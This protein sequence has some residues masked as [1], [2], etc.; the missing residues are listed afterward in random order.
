MAQTPLGDVEEL[1]QDQRYAKYPA[2][3]FDGAGRL[4]AAWTSTRMTDHGG[5]DEIM[6]RVRSRGQWSDPIRLDHGEGFE[7]GVDLKLDSRG[8]LWA[9]WHGLRDGRWGLYSRRLDAEGPQQARAPSA[10]AANPATR[11]SRPQP[12]GTS[13]VG[14]DAWAAERLLT[15]QGVDALHPVV[16]AAA[17]E[18]S[19]GLWVAYEVAVE[20]G[21]TVE[22]RRL[23]SPDISGPFHVSQPV[24][25]PDGGASRRPHLAACPSGQTYLAWDSTLSG[26]YDV[27]LARL[28]SSP[29]GGT[30]SIDDTG[31]DPPRLSDVQPVT[32][33]AFID[34]SPWLSCAPDGSL[35]VAFNSMR[36]HEDAPLRTDRHSGD[37]FIRVLRDGQWLAPPGVAPGA[38]AG[39]VSFGMTVKTPRD[40]VDPYWH[41]KQT[42]N[43]PRVFH[44]GQGAWIIWRSDA[45]G[46]H[47]F[48]LLARYHDGSRW[49]AEFNLTAFSPGR[50]EWPDAVRDPQGGL[51]LAWEG[52]LLPTAER[53]G[54]LGGGDV[55]A[56]N[57]KGNANSILTARL[58]PSGGQAAKVAAPLRPA[59]PEVL[60]AEEKNEPPLA[61]LEGT[62]PRSEDGQ[63][64]I[65]F[66]DPHMHSVLSDGK[67]AWPDQLLEL[68][69]EDLRL[70]FAVVSDHAEMG[71]LQPGEHAELQLTSRAYDQPGR[72]VA[73]SGWEWTAGV[74]AGHRV[75]V[76][77]D[78][79]IRPLSAD[80]PEG[81]SI[82]ELYRH[83]Q[84]HD[85]VLSPH[86]TGNATWGRWNPS[87]RHDET[88][89]PNFEIAS[90]H[91]RFE[92]YGNPHEGRR[93]VP[94]HQYQDALRLGRHVGVMAASDTH[95]L[96]PGEGGLTAV[97]ASDLSREAIFDA[98]R[99]RR[100]YATTG[101]GIVLEFTLDGH[102]MGAIVD[103]EGRSG[104]L[105]M[106]VRVQGTAAVDRVEIVRN[107]IDSYAAVRIE[108]DPHSAEGVFVLYQP[109]RPQ[110]ID[111]LPAAD[112]SSLTF[113]VRDPHPEAGETSYY[114]RV[115]QVDGHQA[116]S[117]PIWI[118]R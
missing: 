108:Q 13:Q 58:E 93:Q 65:Y 92:F 7:S 88:L 20:G 79:G 76:F 31:L 91:G 101:A 17:S 118:K 56:Y 106:S 112:T 27:W 85:V 55:D 98:L 41:W 83:L 46:A 52:Q 115:T 67:T 71:L 97:L 70:D 2:L 82:E 48:D 36:G 4:W 103:Q 38:Q 96:T 1:S 29:S 111:R 45:T 21:F 30:V 75:A 80:R 100:N 72:F 10:Q 99:Q 3:A 8:V 11:A 105:K 116:W 113:T 68:A 117:S 60:S 16:A 78:D 110:E 9:V 94:G 81:D 42:Q 104:A 22:V 5:H 63:W 84:D 77:R 73:L 54:E 62:A 69:R 114:V 14:A 89:E 19:E 12:A 86:H 74:M 53:R 61:G 24:R 59:P 37:A 109:H 47:D 39:Q 23:S 102:P 28:E 33:Q 87:A 90:W 25:V 26:N 57:T 34:D 15:P 6:A 64:T 35:W 44:D 107:L 51:R 18:S 32:R 40:A 50:D 66:G 95:H 49:S 43:Y